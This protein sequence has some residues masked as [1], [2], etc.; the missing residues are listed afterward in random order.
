MSRKEYLKTFVHPLPSG[1][2]ASYMRN[3]LKDIPKE[4]LK[5]LEKDLLFDTSEIVGV[6]GVDHADNPGYPLPNLSVDPDPTA[7]GG[8]EVDE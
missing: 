1:A 3:T 7:P 6:Q 5:F 4:Q 8:R 2:V